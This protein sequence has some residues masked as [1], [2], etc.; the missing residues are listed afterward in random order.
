MDHL[1]LDLKNYNLDDILKL[2]NLPYD[3]TQEDMKN[4][5]KTVL[6]THPD[7]S[8]LDQK[9]FLFFSEAYKIAQNIY[10]FRHKS[11]N[12]TTEYK[13]EINKEHNDILKRMSATHDKPEQ[14]NAWFNTMFESMQI[15]DANKESGYGDWFSSNSDIDDRQATKANMNEMFE[16]KKKEVR[17]I[18]VKKDLQGLNSSGNYSDLVSDTPDYYS[19]DVFSKLPYE[20]LRR[21]HTETVVPVTMED[22]NNR[23]KYNSVDELH[24]DR[25]AQNATARP[26][27]EAQGMKY[28]NDK[29]ELETKSDVER[30]YKLARQEEEAR[31]LNETWWGKLKHLTM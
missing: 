7:K 30:A 20:D 27:T 16:M 29:K 6:M 5:K 28:L 19:C 8:G 11:Q 2:L 22:Y 1:D 26:L 18:V 25:S 15:N 3:F 13:V 21:A 10:E 4:T 12:K 24:A 23:K 31:K 14:F 17:D 9:Y